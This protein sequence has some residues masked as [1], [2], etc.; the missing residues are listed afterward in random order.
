M[1]PADLKSTG[2]QTN[3]QTKSLSFRNLA[4]DLCSCKMK[5][6][7]KCKRKKMALLPIHHFTP[8]DRVGGGGGVYWNHHVQLSV[9]L[10]LSRR[11]LLNHSVFCNKIW[12]DG[13]SSSTRVACTHK[14]GML[15]PRPKSQ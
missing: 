15:S 8:C 4:F 1:L 2:S 14:I 9:C 3:K 10:G 6:N 12:C 11:P 5:T 13:A 7:K